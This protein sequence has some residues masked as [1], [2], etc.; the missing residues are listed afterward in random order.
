MEI[1]GAFPAAGATTGRSLVLFADDG[2]KAG[3]K[4]VRDAVGLEIAS[5]R[6]A[7]SAAEGGVLF[8]SLGVAVV[9]APPDQVM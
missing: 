9:N 1:N 5:A 7:E 2:A 4:A 8:E 3:M 6:D